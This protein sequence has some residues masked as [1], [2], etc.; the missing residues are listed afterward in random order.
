[1]MKYIPLDMVRDHMD[2]IPAFSCPS[3][4]AIR[5]FVRGDER[6]WARIESLAGEFP[7]QEQALQHFEKEFGPF[8]SDMEDRCFILED[9]HGE[10]I[11]TATAWYGQFEGEERGRVHWVGIIPSYQGRKLSKPLLSA[12]MARLA[13]DHQKVYLDTQTTSYPAVNLY[14]SFGFVP[15]LVNESSQEGW[16]LMEQVLKR[17]I[18]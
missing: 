2:H 16:L 4:Y 6:L 8:L 1:M 3:D 10:A 15:Y 14:L 18:L 9:R 5:T 11:G 12:V 7:N 17:K 13:R